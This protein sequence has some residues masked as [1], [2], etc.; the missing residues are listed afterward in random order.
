MELLSRVNLAKQQ[1]PACK[2]D[3]LWHAGGDADVA[4]LVGSTKHAAW[5]ESSSIC[6]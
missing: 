6:P 2:A 4:P 1:I 3:L 5:I